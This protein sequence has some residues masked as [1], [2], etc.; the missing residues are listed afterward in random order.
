MLLLHRVLG[1]NKTHYLKIKT[2]NFDT[3]VKFYTVIY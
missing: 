1:L 2:E 3:D